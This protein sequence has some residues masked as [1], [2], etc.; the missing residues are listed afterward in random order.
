MSFGELFFDNR[1]NKMKTNTQFQTG[2]FIGNNDN[3]T[4]VGRTSGICLVPDDRQISSSPLIISEAIPKISW[5]TFNVSFGDVINI[6]STLKSKLKQTKKK[7]IMCFWFL[8]YC[9][10]KH[11]KT[12]NDL[13]SEGFT[14]RFSELRDMKKVE[15]RDVKFSLNNTTIK[16][17]I[18]MGI[19]YFG[20]VIN[21]PHS[22][23]DGTPV[24]YSFTDKLKPYLSKNYQK[25]CKKNLNPNSKYNTIQSLG[26]NPNQSFKC[27]ACGE[28]RDITEGIID[29]HGRDIVHKLCNCKFHKHPNKREHEIRNREYWDLFLSGNEMGIYKPFEAG[30]DSSHS[31]KAIEDDSDSL[32]LKLKSKTSEEELQRMMKILLETVS[33]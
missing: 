6:H 19:A 8:N 18:E 10:D 23:L 22:Y 29:T 26:I 12:I 16:E 13:N 15:I 3:L 7:L 20:L 21:S 17:L 31:I 2:T 1:P 24:Y 11:N 27:Y 28:V 14:I 33:G 25:E 32:M 5:E 9:I 30:I 4:L